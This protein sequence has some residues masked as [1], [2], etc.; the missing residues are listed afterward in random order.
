[1]CVQFALQDQDV[2]A[3]TIHGNN[4]GR[5]AKMINLVGWCPGY[6]CNVL[7]KLMVDLPSSIATGSQSD[8]TIQIEL[9]LK[10]SQ[11]SLMEEP[12]GK[13]DIANCVRTR[14]K[15]K[16]LFPYQPTLA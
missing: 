7:T 5:Q 3:E 14:R 12:C 2:P 4:L 16:R 11:F 13:Q 8:K 9:A 6:I 10:R 15:S 1:L